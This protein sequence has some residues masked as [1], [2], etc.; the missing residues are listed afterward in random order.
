[1]MIVKPNAFRP[2]PDANDREVFRMFLYHGRFRI[3]AHLTLAAVFGSALC[4]ANSAHAQM[5]SL[6]NLIVNHGIVI[7]GDKVFSNFSYIKSGNMPG[8]SGINVMPIMVSGNL[9][10]RFQGGFFDLPGGGASE[11]LISY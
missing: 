2:S 1:M 5:Y 6:Q 7:S 4:T 8:A 11:A 3:L 10:I 9:G